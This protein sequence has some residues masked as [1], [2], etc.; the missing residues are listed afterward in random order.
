LCKRKRIGDHARDGEFRCAH[1]DF[2]AADR[3]AVDGSLLI[4][5]IMKIARRRLTGAGARP[6]FLERQQSA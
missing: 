5:Q 4:G 2:A 1:I 3:W 6:T